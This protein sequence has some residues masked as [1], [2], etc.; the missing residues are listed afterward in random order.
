MPL[1]QSE[2]PKVTPA[3]KEAASRVN[4]EDAEAQ[5]EFTWDDT[6]QEPFAQE[7]AFFVD[8]K[9]IALDGENAVLINSPDGS[10]EDVANIL[11]GVIG[12]KARRITGD[13][14]YASV[15]RGEQ[16]L[17]VFQNDSQHPTEPLVPFLDPY[18]FT[19]TD[20]RVDAN[21]VD[22]Y[23]VAVAFAVLSSKRKKGVRAIPSGRVDRK[24]ILSVLVANELSDKSP[25]PE[26]AKDA[27]SGIPLVQIDKTY[28]NLSPEDVDSC[29]EIIVGKLRE[30]GL[31]S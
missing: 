18:L 12:G 21:S 8:A 22:G 24:A 17:V 15:L 4:N 1:K 2:L 3:L 31:I 30:L 26:M 6:A 9:A 10:S 13:L 14:M 29:V 27:F 28:D 19:D 11:V 25:L 16:G 23:R 5:S 7:G 20:G